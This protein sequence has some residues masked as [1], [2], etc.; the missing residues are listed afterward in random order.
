MSYNCLKFTAIMSRTTILILIAIN[1]IVYFFFSFSDTDTQQQDFSSIVKVSLRDVGNQL[2]LANKDSTTLVL[3][4][5]L[6]NNNTYELAFQKSLSIAPDNLVTMIKQHLKKSGLPDNYRVE[7]IQCKDK[8]VAY[9]FEMNNA[10]GN[11]IIPCKGRI[12]PE[13]CF[14]IKVKF[15]DKEIA[16]SNN[17]YHLLFF[18][19]SSLFLLF[20]ILKKKKNVKTAVE[21]ETYIAIGQYKFY[22]D[23]NK[24]VFKSQDIKL[25]KKEVELLSIF[26]EKKNKIIK[27]DN[28]MKQVW[29]DQ[30]VFVGRSLD[31]YISKLRKILKEDNAIK[32]TNVHGVGYKLEIN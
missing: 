19:L 31:T 3:P 20:L 16:S 10:K 13:S 1:F 15:T 2:L 28:L 23:E 5:L 7:V 9:S 26:I 25:S 4:V 8:E 29:E 21:K 27:R 14:I 11:D 6:L 18:T 17:K 32:L 24:I 30:G 12:L 22:P